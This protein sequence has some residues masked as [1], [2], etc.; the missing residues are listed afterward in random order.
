MSFQNTILNL[1]FFF[2]IPIFVFEFYYRDPTIMFLPKMTISFII[3]GFAIWYFFSNDDSDDYIYNNNNGDQNVFY[4]VNNKNNNYN[5]RR[6]YCYQ[7]DTKTYEK[8]R[9]INT[10]K[11]TTK[12]FQTPEFKKMYEEKGDNFNNWNWQSRERLQNIKPLNESDI[13][14]DD[15]ENMSIS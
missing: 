9:D 2:L 6:Y 11:E 12:L 14:S 3:I 10:T 1:Y 15:I 8:I 4:N 13:G 5:N 7:M